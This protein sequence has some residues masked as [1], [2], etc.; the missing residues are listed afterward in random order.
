MINRWCR[1]LRGLNHR[2]QMLQASGLLR[3]GGRSW[4]CLL[5][6]EELGRPV[7]EWG[8][9]PDPFPEWDVQE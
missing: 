1:P 7:T 2:L 9:L 6:D 8:K 3:R 5:T 4:M